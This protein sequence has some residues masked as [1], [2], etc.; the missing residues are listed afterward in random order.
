[1]EAEESLETARQPAL[2]LLSGHS[3]FNYLIQRYANRIG[4]TL[5]VTPAAASAESICRLGPEAVIFPSIANL[6]EAQPLTAGLVECDIPIIVCSST[7]DQIRARQ[8]GADYCL[9]HPLVYD[10]FSSVLGAIRAQKTQRDNNPPLN[11]VL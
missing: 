11:P 7:A 10:N 8:L 9:L 2:V 1:M 4:Y 6:E 5:T 3:S